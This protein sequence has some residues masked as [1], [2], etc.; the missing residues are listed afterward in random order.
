MSD[1][2]ATQSIVILQERNYANQWVALIAE[3]FGGFLPQATRELLEDPR[4]FN[5]TPSIRE[6][7]RQLLEAYLRYAVSR[8]MNYCDGIT[9]FEEFE[10]ALSEI[11][12]TFLSRHFAEEYSASEIAKITTE[13]IGSLLES[14]T[15]DELDTECG[16]QMQQIIRPSMRWRECCLVSTMSYYAVSV[17]RDYRIMEYERIEGLGCTDVDVT[18]D[19]SGLMVVL[20]SR[21]A[22]L[23]GLDRDSLK[24][25]TRLLA[26]R[27]ILGI[28]NVNA[29]RLLQIQILDVEPLD[30][31]LGTL[32][33]LQLTE[34]KRGELK[35][36]ITTALG[37]VKDLITGRV[38]SS[39]DFDRNYHMTLTSGGLLTLETSEDKLTEEQI[40]IIKEALE[41]GDYVPERQRRM[42]RLT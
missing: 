14:Q 16:N 38:K 20:R 18:I 4:K 21:I 6:L 42:A 30:L 9:V 31:V 1:L 8:L 13:G 28:P 25:V 33:N 17:G 7:Q 11:I 36:K 35:E 32:P 24:S 34:Q 3:E 5:K 39:I 2:T 12:A 29:D 19:L 40:A 27:L 37:P 10:L 22:N 41:N 23:L 15:F 26:M